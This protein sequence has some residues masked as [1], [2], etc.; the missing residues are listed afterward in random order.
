MLDFEV[1]NIGSGENTRE[2]RILKMPVVQGG[3]F[4][5]KVGKIVLPALKGNKD[6]LAEFFVEAVKLQGKT[7]DEI[8]GAMSENMDLIIDVLGG[9]VES[10]DVEALYDLGI[11]AMRYESYA[12]GRKMDDDR[13]FNAHFKEYPGDLLKVMAFA[14]RVNCTGFFDF[15]DLI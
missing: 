2:Y 1:L 14:I 8:K 7:D 3:K 4:A 5:A 13:H 12:A 15:G 11:E 9:T 6:D 10:M